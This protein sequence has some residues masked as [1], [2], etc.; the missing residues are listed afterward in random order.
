MK[1]LQLLLTKPCT[2]QWSHIESA[3]GNHHCSKCEKNIIDLSGKSD[4]ELLLFFQN[5]KENVCGRVLASQLNRALILPSSRLN[6]Q[7]LVPFALS[8]FIISPADAQNLKPVVL[9][10]EQH[11]KSSSI[12][13]ELSH[14]LPAPNTIITGK[15]V[16]NNNGNALVG[17]K[18]RKKGDEQVLAVTDSTGKFE[19]NIKD[20]DRL[21]KFIFSLNGFAN[22]ETDIHD[23]IVVKLATEQR[24][25]L[26][27]ISIVS[28]NKTPLYY[29][30]AGNKSC[31][32]DPSKI[33]EIS[34]D[35]IERIEVLKDAN[36]TAMYGAKGANG[37]ILIEI[38]KAY[39]KKIKFSK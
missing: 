36:T 18:I 21:S 27:G 8:A 4:K 6:W 39:K 17:V 29:V 25:M 13:S 11:P 19:F 33:S 14:Y 16:Q 20:I 5:K 3:D 23:K 34:P 35:W 10:S 15:V 12:S 1:N 22:V 30:M 7:W 31:I 2:Q 9:Q 32:I 28:K 24:I 26:G 37:V 38:K